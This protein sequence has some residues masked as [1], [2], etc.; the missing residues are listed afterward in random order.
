MTKIQDISLVVYFRKNL[1]SI[2]YDRDLLLGALANMLNR[3]GQEKE[4]I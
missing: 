4:H 2:T 1:K 3:Q